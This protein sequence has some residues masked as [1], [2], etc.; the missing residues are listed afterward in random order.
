MSPP[1]QA[2]LPIPPFQIVT[3]PLF[4][5][6]EPYCKFPSAICYMYDKFPCY[7]IHTTHPLP[8]LLP[9]CPHVLCFSTVALKKIYFLFNC[10]VPSHLS[11][12]GKG[13]P[14]YPWDVLFP[15][16]LGWLWEMKQP[17]FWKQYLTVYQ[18]CTDH[19]WGG[20]ALLSRKTLGMR[21]GEGAWG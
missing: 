7:S 8:S 4:E 14:P 12:L 11:S 6:P 21:V 20:H 13:Q 5:F 16:G 3:E 2:F 10:N 15:I 19:L 18:T 9:P 1:S 17:R